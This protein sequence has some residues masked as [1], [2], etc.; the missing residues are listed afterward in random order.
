MEFIHTADIH[1]GAAPDSTMPWAQERAAE[2]WDSFY[3]LLDE[4]E[5]SGVDILLIA[6]DLFHRQPLKRE[7]KEINY[8]FS[9]LTHAKVVLMAGNHDYIGP[10]SY[11]KDFEWAS[12]VVFFRK[13]HISYIHLASLN[14]I[15]YGMS[16][17]RNEIKENMY[18]GLHPMRRFKDGSPVPQ[19]YHHILLAHGGD[20]EHIPMNMNR[21]RQ[22]GFDYIA[23]GHI[24]KPW[25]DD[26]A[27]IAYAGALEPIDRNDEG[28]HGYIHGRMDNDEIEIEFIPFAKRSYQTITVDMNA[29]MTMQELASNVGELIAEDG[30]QDIYQIVLKGF[31]STDF[32]LDERLLKKT[33]RILSITDMAALDFDFQRLYE[34][35]KDN[36]IGLY[37]KHIT[38]MDINDS[39]KAKALCYGMKAL[40]QMR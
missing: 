12:N 27:A 17:D 1:L 9:Q 31:K 20:A 15:I 18:D 32:E 24:H 10:Q 5:A 35:N 14:T 38:E 40:Y 8:R 30:G 33:G 39:L 13:N 28:V 23:M 11:Y 29:D 21:L 3:R 25:V 4:T 36:I 2:I 6:G 19:N 22:A 37:I 16:Y 26:K 34:E 7:L